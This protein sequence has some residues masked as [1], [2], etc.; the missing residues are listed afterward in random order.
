[1]FLSDSGPSSAETYVAPSALYPDAWHGLFKGELP[2]HLNVFSA[3]VRL[4]TA[5]EPTGKT[6]WIRNEQNVARRWQHVIEGL[7]NTALRYNHPSFEGIY[8]EDGA[9]IVRT[10]LEYIP[11]HIEVQGMGKPGLAISFDKRPGDP[12]PEVLD[13]RDM[14]EP[15]KVLDDMSFETFQA[16]TDKQRLDMRREILAWRNA[17]YH[18]TTGMTSAIPQI[19]VS[20]DEYASLIDYTARLSA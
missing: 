13:L 1:M 3:L 17:R 2:D 5:L 11:D 19:R 4:T 20:M 9:E 16:L 8:H 18:G 14:H 15:V 7:G 12:L 6:T 10:T